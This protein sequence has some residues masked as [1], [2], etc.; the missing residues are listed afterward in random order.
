MSKK[1][2]LTG[3]G[4]DVGKTYVSGLILKKF[5]ESG[6]RAAY[7]K[8]AMSGNARGPDG[9][10]IPGDA[11]HVK[12]VSGIGQPLEGMCPYVYEHPVSP[13]LA[14]RMEGDPVQMHRVLETFDALCG[15]YSYVTVEGSGGILCPLRYEEEKLYLTDFIKARKLPCLLI[16]DGGLGVINSVGL[17]VAYMKAASI[18]LKGIILNHFQPGNPMHE[19]NRRMCEAIT[20][21]KVVTCVKDGDTELDLSVTSL[22]ALYEETEES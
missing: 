17:T 13:H 22:Q 21:C 6:V 4:T 12:A 11:L 2:F 20:G 5:Q 3:T 16:A 9:R 15:E 19:D 1:L 7:Y 10:L 8:A 14:A 18:P